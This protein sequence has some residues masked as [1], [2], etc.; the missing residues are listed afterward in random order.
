MGSTPVTPGPGRSLIRVFLISAAVLLV[1]TVGY[2]VLQEASP[3]DALYMTVITVTTIGYREVFPLSTAGRW[4]TMF[5][6]LSGVGIMLYVVSIV[7]GMIVETDVR[8]V[9]GIRRDRRM[10]M[11][12]SNHIV[13]CG[14]GRTGHALAEILASKGATF[15]V[16][17]TNPELCR[18]LEGAGVHV[19]DGDATTR[20]ALETARIERASTLIACLGDDAHNVYTILLARQLNPSINIVARA[21]EE[22]SE[23]RLRLAGA[24]RIIN[25]YRTG[26]MR[27]A[28][29]A[30]KPTVVDFLDASLPGAG[31]DLELAEVPIH[32]D[33]VL[34]GQTLAGANVRQTYDVIV[35]AIRRSGRSTFNPPPG[36]EILPGDILVALGPTEGLEALERASSK[37]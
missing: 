7:A 34:A 31:G 35:V 32:P 5:L 23:E 36:M 16:V 37:K 10:T 2:M 17:D 12:L 15:V 6:A 3:L 1:G 20:A 30:L 8:R 33:S 29:T 24:D 22:G 19:V 9:L 26:A 18:K 13:V 21:L 4:F 27:L 25:P 28:Y 11:K 14:A